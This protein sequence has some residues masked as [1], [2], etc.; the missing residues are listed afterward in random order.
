MQPVPEGWDCHRRVAAEGWR[1]NGNDNQRATY[2]QWI[3]YSTAGGSS[4]YLGSLRRVNPCF[5]PWEM[6]L[7]SHGFEQRCPELRF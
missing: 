3:N 2:P 5:S 4:P 7:G 1:W 6:N